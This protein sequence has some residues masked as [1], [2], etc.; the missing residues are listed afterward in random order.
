MTRKHRSVHRLLWPVLALTLAL[1]F[2]MALYL[3]PP[4]RATEPAPVTKSQP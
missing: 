3:R 4:P 2:T 1:G